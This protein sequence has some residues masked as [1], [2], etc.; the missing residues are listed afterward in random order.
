MIIMAELQ[1]KVHGLYDLIGERELFVNTNDDIFLG[2]EE[3]HAGHANQFKYRLLQENGK[4]YASPMLFAALTSILNHGT[5]LMTGAHGTG[6]T[7]GAYLAGHFFTGMPYDEIQEATIHGHPQQSE[8]KMIARYHTGSLLKGE[9]VVL[10][11][12]FV[13]SRVKVVNELN[14]LGPDLLNILMDFIDTGKATYGEEV[15]QAEPGPL[16]ATVN[17][18]DSGTY[19]VPP[20]LLDRLDVAV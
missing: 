9:E 16:F 6:K 10:W 14:R 4:A 11:R 1:N 2:H 5:M 7:T 17:Y 8:E 19:D 15:K 13:T 18:T 20:P 12:K 3:V